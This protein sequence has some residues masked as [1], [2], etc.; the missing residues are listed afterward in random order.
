MLFYDGRFDPRLRLELLARHRVTVFCAAATE[1]RR[2]IAEDFT[3]FDLSAL[4]L[5][6]SAGET[7]NPEIVRRWVEKTGVPLLDGYGQTETLMTV[8]NYRCLPVK[9]GSMGKPLPGTEVA[10]VTADR[11]LAPAGA[12][13]EL[14]LP[15]QPHQS[16]ADPVHRAR[17]RRRRRRI[18]FQAPPLNDEGKGWVKRGGPEGPPLL[19]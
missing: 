4:R 8:L 18:S 15:A 9:P 19:F 1:L 3:G 5:A 17:Y 7:V 16:P 13:G 10:L 6:V 2:L 14:G 12:A 11:E